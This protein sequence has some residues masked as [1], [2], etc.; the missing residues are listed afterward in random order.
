MRTLLYG[1]NAHLYHVAVS[2]LLDMLAASA[3]S[4]TRVIPAIGPIT[5]RCSIRR[6]SSRRRTTAPDDSALAGFTT[7]EGVASGL[8]RLADVAGMPFTLNIKSES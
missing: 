2:E 8:R 6:A 7:P 1:G 4:R 5:A 3:G